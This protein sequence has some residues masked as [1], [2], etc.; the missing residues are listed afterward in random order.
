[1]WNV[2]LFSF[3][4]RHYNKTGICAAGGRSDPYDRRDNSALMTAM[5]TGDSGRE[6]LISTGIPGL[7]AAFGDIGEGSNVIFRVTHMRE[8]RA[9]LDPF[10][11]AS[12]RAG[13][14]I[15]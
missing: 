14:K 11:A 6:R 13:R 9:F 5:K 10:T 1:M 3:L 12:R 4:R 15:V 7:D 8:V 2:S